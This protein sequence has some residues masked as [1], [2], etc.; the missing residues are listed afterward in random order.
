VGVAA[1]GRTARR[2]RK[3]GATQ[4]VPAVAAAARSAWRTQGARAHGATPAASVFLRLRRCVR[5]FPCCAVAQEWFV[6][7]DSAL[8]VMEFVR[9]GELLEARCGSR[10]GRAEAASGD[11][12]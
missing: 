7:G 11:G 6:E 12:T 3:H 2:A 8:I 9:G 4:P 10:G 5:L 1:V